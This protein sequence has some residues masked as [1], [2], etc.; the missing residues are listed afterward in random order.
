MRH[1][2]SSVLSGDLAA[3]LH[4][5]LPGASAGPG[6]SSGARVFH[7]I[8]ALC[9]SYGTGLRLHRSHHSAR[10]GA[11]TVPA[12]HRRRL[13][14]AYCATGC[15]HQALH[16]GKTVRVRDCRRGKVSASD[17][18]GF[19]L[20]GRPGEC[21]GACGTLLSDQGLSASYFPAGALHACGDARTKCMSRRGGSGGV[22]HRRYMPR[23]L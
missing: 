8:A 21:R 5:C 13:P 11:G 1:A 3:A 7:G 12:R 16:T 4:A 22:A 6:G 14:Q 19:R 9:A 18:S 2:E 17:L 15:L 23:W 20:H 10:C